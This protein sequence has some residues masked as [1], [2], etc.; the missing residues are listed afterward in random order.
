MAIHFDATYTTNYL[1]LFTIRHV[2]TKKLDEHQRNVGNF[3]KQTN[4]V[5]AVYREMIYN[6]TVL[7]WGTWTARAKRC[8][9]SL[10][11]IKE[12]TQT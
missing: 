3:D 12:H 6:E 4:P 1:D 11:N 7:G 2:L 10:F 5:S 8:P 9:E